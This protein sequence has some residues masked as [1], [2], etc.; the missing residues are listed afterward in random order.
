MTNEQ[1]K[2]PLQ[3][4]PKPKQGKNRNKITTTVKATIAA[5]SVATTLGGWGLFV[6]H[7]ASVAAQTSALQDNI[8]A[9]V[10]A[11]PIPSGT[12]PAT[13]TP[14]VTSTAQATATSTATVIISSPTSVQSTGTAT[15][16]PATETPSTAASTATSTTVPTATATVKVVTTT[17][18][19]AV[20]TTKS[21]R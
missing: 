2:Q 10:A 21:S 1:D 18:S 5:L 4:S 17:S 13:D 16:I 19:K 7:D 9:L 8:A 20:T 6:Q 14:P 11:T 12:A 3:A 15:T